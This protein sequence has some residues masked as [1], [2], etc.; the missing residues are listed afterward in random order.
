MSRRRTNVILA[1]A[2]IMVI[3]PTY[4]QEIPTPHGVEGTVYMSDGV[5]GLS[6][7]MVLL[8][9]LPMNSVRPARIVAVW[10]SIQN[11]GDCL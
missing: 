1:I 7:L 10:H 8:E 3:L 4:A 6:R 11:S 2:I 5:T 9:T